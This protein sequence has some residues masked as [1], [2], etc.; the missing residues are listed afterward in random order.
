MPDIHVAT[1]ARNVNSSVATGNVPYAATSDN[2]FA[3]ARW[4]VGTRFGTDASLAGDHSSVPISRMNDATT[5]V[6]TWS[7]NGSVRSTAARST[8]Q[9]TITFLR[10]QRSTSTPAIGARKKP[11]TMRAIM[12]SEMAAAG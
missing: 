9:E 12:T 3:V 6:D 4:L 8:S 7:M 1:L 5:S 11:G 2:E 10:S